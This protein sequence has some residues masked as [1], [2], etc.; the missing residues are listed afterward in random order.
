MDT[1]FAK[2]GLEGETTEDL[3]LGG[4]V[5]LVQP[6]QGYRA[7][8]DP[9]LLA[10]TV[11]A[12][13]GDAVLDLGCGVGAAALCLA[14]RVPGLNFHAVEIDP[15]VATL[16]RINAETNGL[17]GRMVVTIADA[18]CYRRPRGH[19][20]FDNVMM[21]PPYHAS[22]THRVAAS[23]AKA[24]AN[25]APA[26][27]L[28]AWITSALRALKSGGTL[29]IVQKADRLGDILAA[30]DGKAGRIIVL[31]IQP[32]AEMAA[33]RVIVQ[34]VKGRRT[35]L[36][37]RPALILHAETGYRSEV[38]EILTGNADLPLAP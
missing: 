19:A 31:P 30:L 24:S 34:A 12:A 21:N 33:T 16:A 11:P 10:A 26:S 36:S 20:G 23:T 1:N 35:P 38:L 27:D 6:R 37:L 22:E 28:S 14:A 4:R 5:R 13:P 9:V 32:R 29:T 15:A 17:Q 25:A 7:A 18:M 8:I 3:L 2:P